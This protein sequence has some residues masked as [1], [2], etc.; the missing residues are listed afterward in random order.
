MPILLASCSPPAQSSTELHVQ[1]QLRFKAP[2]AVV[3]KLLPAGFELNSPAVGPSKGFNFAIILVD[4]L[5]AQNAEGKPLPPHTTIPMTIPAKKTATGESVLVVFNG[6]V[7]QAAVPGPYGVYGAAK[8]TVERRSQADAEGKSIIHETWQ[9]KADDGS[10]LE[11]QLQFVRGVPTRG[12]GEPKLHF[13][14]TTGILSP[15]QG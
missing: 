8:L 5:M 10:M 3:Q 11:V 13:R 15:L 1:T 9:G 12:K 14:Q 7:D 4:Y 6:L 2:D